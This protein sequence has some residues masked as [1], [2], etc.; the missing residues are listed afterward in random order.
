VYGGA[1]YNGAD[2][3]L[4]LRRS[5]I[6]G[7]DAI[8]GALGEMIGS[9]ATG[10]YGGAIYNSGN[11][12]ATEITAQDVNVSGG[13][14]EKNGGVVVGGVIYNKGFAKIDALVAKHIVATGGNVPEYNYYDSPSGGDVSGGV[15]FNDG[16]LSAND[17][18]IS[19]TNATA[20]NGYLG[21]SVYGGVINNY[22][23]DFNLSSSV[24]SGTVVATGASAN[25]SQSTILYGGVIYNDGDMNITQTTIFDTNATGATGNYQGG[26]VKGGAIYNSGTLSFA[27]S[28]LLDTNATSE[29]A[30]QAGLMEGG[31][32]FN[33]SSGSCSIEN[34]TISRTS[35]VAGES[36]YHSGSHNYGTFAKG[37]AIFNNGSLSIKTSLI[38]DTLLQGGIHTS[39][40]GSNE[41][42]DALGGAIYIDTLGT[43]ILEETNITKTTTICPA[44]SLDQMIGGDVAGGVLYSYSTKSIDIKTTTIKDTT[45]IAGD[46]PYKGGNVEGGVIWNLTDDFNVSNLTIEN[47]LVQ[48]GTNTD[49]VEG[50][51]R[52]GS[53]YG[54]VIKSYGGTLMILYDTN[55]LHTQIIAGD[56]ASNGGA[57]QGGVF[58]NEN[59]E[60]YLER[61]RILDTNL[62][63]GN[64]TMGIAGDINGSIFYNNDTATAV[65][66]DLVD[67]RV[68]LGVGSDE[69]VGE[70][71]SIFGSSGGISFENDINITNADI[72]FDENAMD[73]EAPFSYGASLNVVDANIT[74]IGS[75]ELTPYKLN[76]TSQYDI[77]INGCSFDVSD[78]YINAT[79]TLFLEAS[80]IDG[81]DTH[82]VG[83]VDVDNGSS[84]STSEGNLIIDGDVYN[85]GEIRLD[86]GSLVLTGTASGNP[87]ATDYL[88][89]GSIINESTSVNYYKL[90]LAVSEAANEDTILF[91]GKIIGNDLIEIDDKNVTIKGSGISSS[92]IDGNSDGT[93][94]YFAVGD[95]NKLTLQDINISNMNSD[96]SSPI[97]CFRGSA[98]IDNAFFAN[99]ITEKEPDDFMYG[100]VLTA[101][102]C[103]IDIQNSQFVGNAAQTGGTIVNDGNITMR[104]S[105][106]SGSYAKGK[107]GT[108]SNSASY[109]MGGAIVN[110]PDG[111]LSIIDSNISGSNAIGGDAYYNGS[112]LKIQDA[113]AGFGGAIFNMGELSLKRSII[114]DSNA[115]G[116]DGKAV[117]SFEG[118]AKGSAIYNLGK[119][120][121]DEVE[122]SN[123]SSLSGN[124]SEGAVVSRGD[125]FDAQI[126][127]NNS[128]FSNN[129]AFIGGAVLSDE[130]KTSIANSRF[131]D[132]ESLF[133]GGA[134][135]VAGNTNISQ[136]FFTANVATEGGAIYAMGGETNITSSTIAYNQSGVTSVGPPVDG[137]YS[138][139][140]IYNDDATVNLKNTIVSDN[141]DAGDHGPDCYGDITSLGYN[142]LSDDS[143]C[144]FNAQ[145]TD[146]VGVSAQLDSQTYELSS[147][148]PA[149]DSGVMMEEYDINGT[150]RPQGNG[151]DIGAVETYYAGFTTRYLNSHFTFDGNTSFLDS[152]T[153]QAYLDS[154]V[155][156][157]SVS[158]ADGKYAYDLNDSFKVYNNTQ[159]L[160]VKLI[161]PSFE[162]SH[163]EATLY[164]Q[165]PAIEDITI[166]NKTITLQDTNLSIDDISEIDT[167]SLTTSNYKSVLSLENNNSHE[168]YTYHM[169]II[170]GYDYNISAKMNDGSTIYYDGVSWN[171]VYKNSFNL[172]SQTSIAEINFQSPPKFTIKPQR[173]I[174]KSVMFEDFNISFYVD[175][176]D[177]DN[178][179]LN[180]SI[181]DPTLVRFKK[182]WI[183]N[184]EELSQNK[185]L[186]NYRDVN[187]SVEL[188]SVFPYKVGKSAINFALTDSTGRKS[189]AS[190]TLDVNDTTVVKATPAIGTTPFSTTLSAT[191]VAVPSTLTFFQWSIEGNATPSSNNPLTYTFTDIGSSEINATFTKSGNTYTKTI[192]VAVTGPTPDVTLHSGANYV[193][194]SQYGKLRGDEISN[195]FGDVK[196]THIL[197]N[198][199]KWSYWDKIPDINTSFG[200]PK[201]DTLTSK[202]GFIVYATGDVDI[203]YPFNSANVVNDFFN[204]QYYEDGWYL[205]GVNERKYIQDI[206]DMVEAKGKTLQAINLYRYD[207]TESKNKLLFYKSSNPSSATF[208]YIEPH[209]SFWIKV[210]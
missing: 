61:V 32:I 87:I 208:N 94:T 111:N 99:N 116:G 105:I 104:N 79:Q 183:A 70:V 16:S 141:E 34:S 100:G 129:S 168:S 126:D 90:S 4:T 36:S 115:T 3:N 174:S 33:H 11:L 76:I 151:Y 64:A 147:T 80:T 205:V 144:T 188:A 158:T 194:F 124:A 119:V 156:T 143:N 15:I 103:D 72:V 97:T 187:I 150:L 161:G 45:I 148:S 181:S 62:T 82:I 95:G 14:G 108:Y 196:I 50:M 38:E 203:Y 9:Y 125:M 117:S 17:L 10:V 42:G 83:N 63:S 110:L 44:G 28:F 1:L 60:L 57:I 71:D 88:L 21:G 159:A 155:L 193:S 118:D 122:I 157:S 31:A 84:L 175:D 106:I 136:S 165:Q 13:Y 201:F 162:N 46:A 40:S 5:N 35:A 49:P 199:G 200:M 89:N 85:A 47:T 172:T 41:N 164:K 102:E 51:D 48:A 66:L 74:C 24:I 30:G 109:G 96:F 58:Y 101:R 145:I 56:G 153:L 149:I 178:L 26:D 138:G 140:G 39:E 113:E 20:G 209:E 142:I 93:N 130:A 7:V 91:D 186:S 37:G 139:G 77:Y 75:V 59:A 25:S 154:A 137:Q 68:Y 120:T 107:D 192:S 207:S 114:K 132:N 152:S 92:I 65:D 180:I 204:L 127:I 29:D 52:G 18:D 176:L 6:S 195:V 189:F 8:S 184:T 112:G 81:N 210:D 86:S 53:I 43:L 69:N 123:C 169:P 190:S 170:V 177:G 12:E 182:L 173:E 54:G 134:L 166:A 198:N 98:D 206:K 55:I 131:V 167:I 121:L 23:Q 146:Q 197:K 128:T 22:S 135:F 27:S 73:D 185:T 171:K 202:E 19:D 191:D 179:D 2:A 163:F 67:A 78:T 133:G 160:Y